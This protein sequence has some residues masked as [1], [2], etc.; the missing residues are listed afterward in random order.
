MALIENKRARYDYE[1]TDRIEA[2][3]SLVGHEVKSIKQGKASLVG[4]Y[5]IIR[6]DE[7]FLVGAT[8]QPYQ[9][10]NTPPEYNPGRERKLL[11]SK[12]EIER[13]IGAEK[14]RSTTIIPLNA[15][16]SRG[17]VK[18]EVGIARGKK[19]HDKRQTIKEREDKRSI[20]REIKSKR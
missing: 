6:N 9:E 3:V 8:V 1:I 15:H 20:E 7:A 11:L 2:G 19:K 17:K 13:L 16:L 5:I 4:S 10:K 14:E 12:K 18:I